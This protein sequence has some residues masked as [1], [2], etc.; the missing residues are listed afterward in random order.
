MTSPSIAKPMW[1]SGSECK[2]G[3]LYLAAIAY[4]AGLVYD[5]IY[6]HHDHYTGIT[7]WYGQTSLTA[8]VIAFMPVKD[9]LLYL[10]GAYYIDENYQADAAILPWRDGEPD[11]K[12]PQIAAAPGSYDILTWDEEFGWSTPIAYCRGHIPLEEFLKAAARYIPLTRKTCC[13]P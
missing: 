11:S 4:P 12:A 10:T 3:I 5:A 6:R 13:R 2:V 9:A 8:D 7:S 1:L